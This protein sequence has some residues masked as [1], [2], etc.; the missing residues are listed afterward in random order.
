MK[1]FLA[2]LMCLMMLAYTALADAKLYID[3]TDLFLMMPDNWYEDTLTQDDIDDGMVGYYYCD[4]LDMGIY[5]DDLEGWTLD[6]VLA[7]YVED[8]PLESGKTQINGRD[9]GYAVY[10]ETDE[11]GTYYAI[12]YLTEY[13]DLLITFAFWMADPSASQQ[14]ADI[15]NT[16][17]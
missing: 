8:N 3:E 6:E 17:Q 14:A 12:F 5:V 13:N 16:L 7:S 9:F 2:I 11:D 4:T 1:K 15:L 10:E